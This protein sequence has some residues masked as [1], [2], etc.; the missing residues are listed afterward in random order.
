MKHLRILRDGVIYRVTSNINRRVRDLRLRDI[1]AMFLVFIKKAEQK[2]PFQLLNFCI[3]DN[4]I[5][6]IIKPD[7]G[8]SMKRRQTHGAN[9]WV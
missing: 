6:L 7:P 1:K 4:H 8:Q 3:M 9:P 5:H 2:Y